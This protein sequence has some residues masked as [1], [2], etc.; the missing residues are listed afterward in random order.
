MKIRLSIAVAMG[1]VAASAQ[2][3]PIADV[4]ALPA[5]DRAEISKQQQVFFDEYQKNGM[6]AVIERTYASIGESKAI[7]PELR[8]TLAQLDKCGSLTSVQRY[9]TESTGSLVVR[10]HFA[11]IQGSCLLQ[12][13]LTY[14]KL[15]G[16]WTFNRFNVRT[17]NGNDW[18][19]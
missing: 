6:L 15:P 13:D 17:Y 9:K 16:G 3:I 14:L 18:A 5:V 1:L 4:Y 12:W 7:T 11:V 2:A 8:V 10:D 19:F